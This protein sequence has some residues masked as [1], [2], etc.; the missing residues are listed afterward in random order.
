MIKMLEYYEQAEPTPFT[1]TEQQAI[2]DLK[3]LCS[4][5]TKIHFQTDNYFLTKFLRVCDWNAKAAYDAIV[6][7]YELKVNE[8]NLIVINL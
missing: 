3:I 8:L 7:F 6:Y 4:K 2:D 1:D 5:N